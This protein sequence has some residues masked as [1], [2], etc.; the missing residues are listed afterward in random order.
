M[1]EIK[2]PC[3]GTAYFDHDS[4]FSYRCSTCYAVIGSIGQPEE[5]KD[6]AQMYA[7]WEALGGQNWDYKLGKPGKPPEHLDGIEYI[8]D[9]NDFP[10]I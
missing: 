5:C 1:D 6:A 9:P 3:G 7:N 4:G 2:L 8:F 10:V